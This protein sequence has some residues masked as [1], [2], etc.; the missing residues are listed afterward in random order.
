MF[1]PPKEKE[2]MPMEDF[3]AYMIAGLADV[4]RGL[5]DLADRFDRSAE[6]I[7]RKFSVQEQ[8]IEELKDGQAAIR[9]DL[10]EHPLHCP[11]RGDFQDLEKE[12]QQGR[13]PGSISLVKKLDDLSG[14]VERLEK[15][16]GEFLATVK[17]SMA[18]SN[19]LLMPGVAILI[20]L[21]LLLVLLNADKVFPH[22]LGKL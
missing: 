17:T 8:K 21:V 12:I 20:F 11:L 16:W 5:K 13:H 6:T 14:R 22:I 1:E 9:K 3:H 2:P 15:Q 10:A 19:R 7:D 4:T 18:W